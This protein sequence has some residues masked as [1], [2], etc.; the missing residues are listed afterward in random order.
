MNTIGHPLESQLDRASTYLRDWWRA[1]D[2]VDL[3]NGGQERSPYE[4]SLGQE[5]L[6]QVY[7]HI[8]Q[9]SRKIQL[10]AGEK[11]VQLFSFESGLHGSM[12]IR[13]VEEEYNLQPGQAMDLAH[14]RSG[15]RNKPYHGDL[16]AVYMG[17]VFQTHSIAI[18]ETLA[19]GGS[20]DLVSGSAE[21]THWLA[22][23]DRRR[24]AYAH[25]GSGKSQMKR[26]R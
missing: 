7:L 15:I 5:I 20:L 23:S 14:F 22:Y 2:T 21:D 13:A 17:R 10:T 19:Q 3:L 26:L 1:N 4:R 12:D 9:R 16:P 25:T 18:A 11:A 24:V 8:D 6:R